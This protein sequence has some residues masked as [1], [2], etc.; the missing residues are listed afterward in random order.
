MSGSVFAR[1]QLTYLA[2]SS[3]GHGGTADLFLVSVKGEL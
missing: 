1:A 2:S 3:R